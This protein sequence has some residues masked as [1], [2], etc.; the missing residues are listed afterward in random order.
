MH[1]IKKLVLLAGAV[2]LTACAT[3]TPYQAATNADTRNGFSEL[4]IEKDRTRISFDGNSLTKRDTVETYLL[5]RAAELTKQSGY[6]Y[7]TLTDR[8]TDKKT[9][10][11]STGF[12][13]PYYGFFD[14]SYFHPSYGWSRPHYRSRFRSHLGFYDPY[15]S[16]FGYD[17]FGYS[18]FGRSRFGNDFDYR[19]VTRYRASAEV[20]FKRGIKPSNMDN[21]FSAQ[22]VLDNLSDKIIYPEVKA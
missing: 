8:A 6:D 3:A 22:E 12:Q 20:S 10:I 13:D 18:P 2:V 19:E 1:A 4:K 21:A 11:R 17:S 16:A 15:Y 7:F 14:Y 5:Y 9:R